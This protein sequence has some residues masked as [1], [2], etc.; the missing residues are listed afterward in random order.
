MSTIATPSSFSSW[1]QHRLARR[2]LLEHRL[3]HRD[4]GAVHAGDDVLRRR[5][6]AG[7]D[8]H[9]DLEARAGHPDR[10]ADAVLLVDDE[11]LRQHVQDLAA[12]RQRHRLGGVDRAPHVLA[13]DLAVLPGDRDDAAAVE[14]L[15]V[16]GRQAEVNRIDLD[17]GGQLRLVDR[18]LDRLD[19][20]LEIDDD[21]AAD[22]AR[23]RQADADDVE[24]AVVGHLADDGGDLRRADVEPDQVSFLA[25]PPDPPFLSAG[26]EPSRRREAAALLTRLVSPELRRSRA[27][28]TYNR[29]IEPQVHVVDVRHPLAQRRR[30]VDVRLQPLEELVVAEV[31]QRRVAVEQ[32]DRV[33]QIA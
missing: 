20:R 28:L 27:G 26:P 22:A 10:R 32:H 11:V 30:D 24:P 14:R 4:A 8:V 5:G 19:G 15:D 1:R 23:V 12:A 7:D 2:Q 33:V 29:S 25:S 21:A 6:A 3:D 17:A 31:Q 16:R 9:V 18:L 13:R